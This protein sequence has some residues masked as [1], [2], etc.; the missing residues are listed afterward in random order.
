[1]LHFPLIAGYMAVQSTL[2]L[3]W[4]LPLTFMQMAMPV[5]PRPQ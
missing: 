4:M 2:T 3:S 5:V 1:M